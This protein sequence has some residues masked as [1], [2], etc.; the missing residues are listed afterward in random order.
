[1]IGAVLILDVSDH[2]AALAL[3]EIDVDVGHGDALGIEEALEHQVVRE[4]IQL[5]DTQRVG[6]DRPRRAPPPRA[7]AD[8]PVLRPVDEV[9]DHEEVPIEA[10]VPD[11]LELVLG[12]FDRFATHFPVA[13]TD[14]VEH[15]LSQVGLESVSLWHLVPRKEQVPHRDLDVAAI[16]YLE[17]GLARAG[18]A[19]EGLGHLF[20]G[21]QVELVGIEL[22]TVGVR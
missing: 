22:E 9:L 3:V 13:A 11:D 2:V 4:G 6:D 7:H 12:P 8:P 17:R 15:E 10:H 14:T 19:R 21:L 1:V 18:P 20:G 16:G 5:G